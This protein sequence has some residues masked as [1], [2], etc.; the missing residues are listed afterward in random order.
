MHIS[1]TRWTT[2]R[3]DLRAAWVD[4]LSAADAA[5]RRAD[6]AGEW[7]HLERAHVLS[8]PIAY[9]HV[10]THVAMLGYGLRRRDGREIVGQLVRLA[11]AAPGSWTGRYPVGNTGGAN[12]S[13]LMAMP[14]AEDLRDVLNRSP[15]EPDRSGTMQAIVQDQY[16]EALDVLRLEAVDRPAIGDNDVLLRVHAAGVDRGVWHVMAGLPYP[17]R[18]AGYGVQRPKN[19]MRGREVAGR[20]EAVGKSVTEFRA[21]DEVFGIAEGAFAEYARAEA[22]KLAPKPKNLT[23]AQAAASTISALT[24]LQGVRD[25][26]QVKAG[27]KVLV[28]GASGGVG[29]FAVQ[30]AKAFGA[31]VT[32]VASTTKVD[33]VRSIGADQVIDYTK[34]DITDGGTQYDVILDIGGNRTLKHLRRALAQ[35]G[36]LVIMGGETGGKYLGG[37]DRGFRAIVLSLFVGQKLRSLMSSENAADLRALTELIESG[38]V[39][40]VIDRTYPLSEAPAAIQSM[41]DGHVRGKVVINVDQT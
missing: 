31:E 1:L 4:E 27:Q 32:G 40:P 2:K 19:R 13:A 37:F 16:G 21:G 10:R 25:R 38:K 36:T 22:K 11:V 5:R 35:R 18:V 15:I 28:I 41:Q 34:T 6:A 12:V 9:A 39:T 26:G 8:Q 29:T 33:M 3:S 30:I 7:R 23:F 24:A 14:I 20:V 17:V